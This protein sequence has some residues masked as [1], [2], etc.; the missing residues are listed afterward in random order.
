MLG[1]QQNVHSFCCC[2]RTLFL[3]SSFCFCI[4]P[5]FLFVVCQL[6][7]CSQSWTLKSF[8][9][10]CLCDA[11]GFTE[12]KRTTCRSW[13]LLS[14]RFPGSNSGCQPWCQASLLS[15]SLALFYFI[16]FENRF[17]SFTL[18]HGGVHCVI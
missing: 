4:F 16:Y 6:F 1:K 14:Y 7:L 12:V 15:H 13:L 11:M 5:L 18:A 2:S 8:E 10:I 9:F 3:S 17:Q